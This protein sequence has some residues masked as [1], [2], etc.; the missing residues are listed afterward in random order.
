MAKETIKDLIERRSIRKYKAEQIKDEELEQILKAGIYAA[1]G[2][3]KQPC[4]IIVVQDK[5]TRDLLMALNRK[6][7]NMPEDMDHSTAHRQSW[8]FFTIRKSARSLCMTAFLLWA[9]C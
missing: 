5:E 3:N 1:S 8:S 4:K 2:M 9:T 6:A 7:G